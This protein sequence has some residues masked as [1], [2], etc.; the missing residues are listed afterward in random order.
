MGRVPLP[1]GL[2]SVMRLSSPSVIRDGALLLRMNLIHFVF[3]CIA[4]TTGKPHTPLDGDG[5]NRLPI[6]RT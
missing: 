2:M 4:D 3:I 6:L 5:R 1:R